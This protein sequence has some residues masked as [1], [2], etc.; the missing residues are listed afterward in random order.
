MGRTV[1]Q[2]SNFRFVSQTSKGYNVQEL[3]IASVGNNAPNYIKALKM[4]VLDSV[5]QLNRI[6]TMQFDIATFNGVNLLEGET[7]EI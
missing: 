7:V 3:T 4:T 6:V 5:P 1:A 2:S